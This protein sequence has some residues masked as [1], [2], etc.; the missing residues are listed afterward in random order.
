M[1]TANFKQSLATPAQESP[2]TRFYVEAAGRYAPLP[3]WVQAV[4]ASAV[5]AFD[6]PAPKRE[7]WTFTNLRPLSKLSPVLAPENLSIDVSE[8]P[9]KLAGMDRL[10]FVNGRFYPALSDKIDGLDIVQTAKAFDDATLQETLPHAGELSDYPFAALGNAAF[11]DGFYLSLKAGVTLDKPVEVLFYTKGISGDAVLSAPRNFIKLGAGA[12]ATVICREAGTGNYLATPTTDVVLEKQAALKF[13]RLQQD[14][15]TGYNFH[16]LF[17]HQQSQSEFDG[18][19]LNTGAALSRLDI[20][21]QLLEEDISCNIRGV[22]MLRDK[23]VGD[24]TL[25]VDHFEA[26]G[27]SLQRFKG[28]VDAQAR[29]VFQGKIHVRRAAQKTDGYQLNH[30]LLLSDQAEADSKPEL[31]IYADDVKCSHG[32]ATGKLDED[33]LFYLRARGVDK[34]AAKM[35]LIKSFIA[36]DLETITDDTVRDMYDT[37]MADWLQG[38]DETAGGL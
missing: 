38:L 37:V 24:I 31:E 4:K 34:A 12:K 1:T 29:A 7:N 8:L 28:V 11:E 13:Y 26:H 19:T 27:T 20:R 5:E 3:D 17:L 10:V 33:A 35:L 9:A 23:Q 16:T 30:A 6:L 25:N 22:Y 32:A 2:L 15:L 21:S 36:E 18:F 14:D